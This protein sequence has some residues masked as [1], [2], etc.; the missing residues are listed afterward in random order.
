MAV[1]Q[2]SLVATFSRTGFIKPPDLQ[3]EWT[4]MPRAIVN[5]NI[6]N[7]VISAKPNAD[8]QELI[9]SLVFEQ[10]FAYRMADFTASL[11]QDVANDWITRGYFELTNAIRNTESGSTQRH[12][13]IL[14]DATIVPGGGEAWFARAAAEIN[15]PRY[16][17]QALPGTQ[18]APIVTFKAT[19]QNAAVG[20]AGTFNFYASFFEYDIEQVERFPVHWPMQT[21]AR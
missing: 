2:D 11:L 13:I 3:R 16:V 17:I 9:V 6:L 10:N 15:L 5:Y 7:G 14:D 19:N 1:V 21:W 18:A 8:Q 12:A 20:A 4:A